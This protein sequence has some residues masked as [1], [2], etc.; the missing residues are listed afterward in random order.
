MRARFC[1]LKNEND[2]P[3]FVLKAR[4]GKVILVSEEYNRLRSALNGIRSVQEN[5]SDKSSYVTFVGEDG[6]YYF[7][8]RAKNNKVIGT[9]EGYRTK[10]GR[11]FGMRSVMKNAPNAFVDENL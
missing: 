5:S 6:Q 10:W 1:V 7:N 3:Y 8:L 2:K 4:N 9:S 11:Y